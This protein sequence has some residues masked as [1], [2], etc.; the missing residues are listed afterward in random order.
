VKITNISSFI[1][2]TDHSWKLKK[3]FWKHSAVTPFKSLFVLYFPF[4]FFRKSNF[5]IINSLFSLKWIC[6]LLCLKQAPLLMKA[7]FPV[8]FLSEA[9]FSF[10]SESKTLSHPSVAQS[11]GCP[12]HTA[13][14]C[15]R[16]R[17]LWVVGHRPECHP[18]TSS[19]QRSKF[20]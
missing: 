12:H 16:Q 20:R 7:V 14:N 15:G 4:F 19:G 18:E 9:S 13:M 1:S 11:G 6:C 17:E 5:T 8:P 10:F 2:L 3:S